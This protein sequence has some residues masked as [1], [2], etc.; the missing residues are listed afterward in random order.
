MIDLYAE[1]YTFVLNKGSYLFHSSSYRLP[2]HTQPMQAGFMFFGMSA[3]I[4]LWHA[5]ER[6]TMHKEHT[7]HT[8]KPFTACLNIYRMDEDLKVRY[9]ED[10]ISQNQESE[11][12]RTIANKFPCMHPQFAYH[13]YEHLVTKRGPVELDFELTLPI[14]VLKQIHITPVAVYNIDVHTLLEHST[15]NIHAFNPLSTLDF[16]KNIL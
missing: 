6:Y 7:N 15:K 14:H 10:D 13:S 12:Y 16:T 2:F 3:I 4:S 8:T 9:I 5:V 11:V 1:P